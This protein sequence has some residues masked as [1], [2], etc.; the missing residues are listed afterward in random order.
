MLEKLIGQSY[1]Q[2]FGSVYH[3][4]VGIPMGVSPGVYLANY[5]MCTYELEHMQ[6]LAAHPPN[7]SVEE[8]LVWGEAV[9]TSPRWFRG[10]YG[11]DLNG[12]LAVFIW[13]QWRYVLRFVDDLQV[14]GHAWVQRLLYRDQRLHNT[15][16][17]GVY[18]RHCPLEPST[19]ISAHLVPYMAVLQRFVSVG[20]RLVVHTTLYDRRRDPQFRRMA[21]LQYTHASSA[22]ARTTLTNVC[23][24]Q[25]LRLL[26]LI[27][28]HADLLRELALLVVKLHNQG[29][30]P[31]MVTTCVR[32]TVQRYPYYL[33]GMDPATF[34]QR[35]QS[36]VLM[37]HQ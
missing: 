2:C 36:S 15:T 10:L 29:Y 18:P 25:T 8:A 22:V 23:T 28:G 31:A 33:R 37:V 7:M 5:Y 14:V 26:R 20:G 12:C 16:I 34:M 24:G 35:L 30:P 17:T 4:V 6:C 13:R 32:R 3:Q 21:I 27:S 11:S 19:V 9:A 1:I